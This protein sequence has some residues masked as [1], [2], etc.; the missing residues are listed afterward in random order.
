MKLERTLKHRIKWRKN[1]KKYIFKHGGNP[2]DPSID[3][4]LCK[5]ISSRGIM[6]SCDIYSSKPVSS[7]KQLMDMIFQNLQSGVLYL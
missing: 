7:I 6:Q 5:Y 3:N 2:I 4:T 1:I